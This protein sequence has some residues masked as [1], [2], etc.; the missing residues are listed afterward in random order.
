VKST[1]ASEG[2]NAHVTQYRGIW[3][4]FWQ[5]IWIPHPW[6]HGVRHKFYQNWTTRT[7]VISKKHF[8]L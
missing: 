2:V 6:K 8:A 1:V 5:Q 7:K 3:Q 4:Q